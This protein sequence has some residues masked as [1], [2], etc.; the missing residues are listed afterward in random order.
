MREG[1]G[2][3]LGASRLFTTH[4]KTI[5]D[6]V[7]DIVPG[8][9]FPVI[10]TD[11]ATSDFF[12][13]QRSNVGYVE[14]LTT[15]VVQVPYAAPHRAST[16]PA[17]TTPTTMGG[18]VG[19]VS[20]TLGDPRPGRGRGLAVPADGGP[21]TP[22]RPRD[23]SKRVPSPGAAQP[24]APVHVQDV[25]HSDAH[26]ALH[27]RIWRMLG[28]RKAMWTGQALSV[29]KATHHPID[30][31]AGA[32][33]VRFALLR[34]GHTARE[35]QPAESKRQRE[36]DFIELTSSQWGFPVVLVR[37][38]DGTVRFLRRSSTAERRD[39]EG[40]LSSARDGQ[41][42]RQSRRPDHLH[43]AEFQ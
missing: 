2:Q 26:M 10:V 32:R 21:A 25:D 43:D 8:L 12:L 27:T 14:L 20:G 18:V 36:A 17:F 31:N 41:V 34:A 4:G 33:P 6:G 37:K 13:W 15:G 11:F 30:L 7:H 3:V 22:A 35:A 24:E 39:Q 23:P 16:F 28:Q 5:A 42:H 1:L 29:I 19:A 40:F 9:S 38:K